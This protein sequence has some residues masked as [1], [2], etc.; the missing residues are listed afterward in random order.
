MLVKWSVQQDYE[1][2]SSVLVQFA[3]WTGR[4]K[5]N[6]KGIDETSLCEKDGKQQPLPN[7]YETW[8]DPKTE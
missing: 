8:F 4:R 5:G 1:I 3:T 6:R 2:V 7:W